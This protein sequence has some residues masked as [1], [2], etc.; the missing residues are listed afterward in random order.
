MKLKPKAFSLIFVS[1]P[2]GEE[3][4]FGKHYKV[5]INLS[6]EALKIFFISILLLI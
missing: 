2:I 3:L 6:C 1:M 4:S 5:T